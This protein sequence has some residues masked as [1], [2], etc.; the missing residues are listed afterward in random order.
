M[1]AEKEGVTLRVLLGQR[2]GEAAQQLEGEAVGDPLVV[3]RLQHVLGISLRELG[4]LEQAE[5]VLVK[6]CRTRE[7]L[8]GADHL[9]TVATK[10]HLATLYRAQGKYALAEALF[11]EVLAVRTAKL[12]A[13]HPDTL[14]SQHHL[15]LLYHSQ[16][17]YALAET[18]FKEVLAVRT[19][20]LGADH[21]D[22]L[23]SQHRL[24]LLYRSQEKYALAETLCKEVLAIR[25]AKLGADHL[26]TL[27]S[28]HLLAT[29]YR[30]QEKYALAETLFKEVLAVR[31]AKLGADHPD[32]LTSQ[33]HLAL[34]YWS[35]KKLDQSIP[36]LEETLK[37]RKA[38]L[39]PDHPDTLGTQVDLGVNYC[40]AGRFADAI[41]LLEEVH[42][43]GPHPHMGTVGNALLTAYVRAG[44]TT[45]ATALVTE[46]V[47]AARQW[48]PADSPELAAE[49]ADVGQ[50]LL[51][52]KAYAAA[53]PLLRES[54]SLGEQK[55]PDAWDTHQR[56]P[57]RRRAARPAEV[58]RRRAP[59]AARLR[60]AEAD[61][62]RDLPVKDRR[63]G[64]PW[65]GW[66]SST[67]PG[68]SRTRRRSGGRSWNHPVRRQHRDDHRR[69]RHRRRH[70]HGR[71]RLPG[72]VRHPDHPRRPDQRDD[73]R[74]VNGD[75][76]AEP[77]ETFVVNLSSPTNATIADGQGVGTILDDEPR[78]SISDVTKTEGK[79]NQTTLF[80]F[81]V[82][83]SAAYD[84]PVTMSFQHR[85]RHRDDERQRLRRQDR[86]ADLRPRRDDEDDHH[87]SQG[88]QQEGGQRDVLPG[89]V[90]QQQQFAVHQ[91]ARHR[92]D[93][94]RRLIPREASD[95]R[96][97]LPPSLMGRVRRLVIRRP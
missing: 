31:T 72:R 17:K 52:A 56:D 50:T 87:R 16:G 43:K 41:P 65:S 1:A 14:T 23:T 92:H 96:R 40:D 10:H 74:A 55:V 60:G 36:L 37:L 86:H 15:A 62:G 53:E 9:D 54:L 93:P 22:T 63:C 8:L 68:A 91:E 90:R 38:K 66:S 82:T 84:Q 95:V 42:R 20:K 21:P 19:A 57:A 83:L 25:T 26:D 76:L 44:K 85:E 77:N 81:T 18:L 27:A 78:I 32:T 35:M 46:A 48:F 12:G 3:A 94:E 58:C 70:R 28:K 75:R 39:D 73:H 89:P 80:T 59:V 49:L 69:L 71:Q 34:L 47:R 33:H 45:E 88:R 51:D 4:H 24:A 11:K 67:T 30:A 7:R 5:V 13:D 79:K 61:P 29:L 64:T 97:R 6:A 2:L